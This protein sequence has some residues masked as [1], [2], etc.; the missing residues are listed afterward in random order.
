MSIFVAGQ[1]PEELL[2]AAAIVVGFVL[3]LAFVALLVDTVE[4]RRRKRTGRV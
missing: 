4:M 2:M 1:W 3:F